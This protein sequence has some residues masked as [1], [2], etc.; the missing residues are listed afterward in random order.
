MLADRRALDAVVND[1]AAQWLNL[2]RVEEVVVDPERYPNYDL[3]LMQA[4]QQETELFVGSTLREDRSVV[5]L[6]DANYTFVNERLARHYNI[7][8]IYGSRFRRVTLTDEARMGLLG[9]GSILTLTSY[10]NRTSPV[11]RGA[12]VLE[13]I[14]GTPP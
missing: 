7:P 9:K 10:P 3:S 6:L 14:L 8:G 2:R 11:L 1:F 4:F 13:N 12:W 5:D